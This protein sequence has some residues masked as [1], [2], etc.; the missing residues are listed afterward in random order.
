MK[1]LIV[2]MRDTGNEM[3]AI[4][5]TLEWFDHTVMKVAVGRPR[6][7]ME[8]LRGDR[9]TDFD[10]MIISGHGD[11]GAF[12]VPEL[13]AE[14][15]ESDEPRD[16]LFRADE[17]RKC[18]KLENK[19]IMSLCCTTGSKEMAEVFSEKNEYYAY[20]GYVDGDQPLKDVVDWFYRHQ[21]FNETEPWLHFKNGVAEEVDQA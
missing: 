7:F 20:K 4:R 8:V 11:E 5:Q 12:L 15:Y 10:V 14:I 19:I 3:E 1:V 13:A 21:E 16:R 17:V 2:D 18:L 6:H 9:G